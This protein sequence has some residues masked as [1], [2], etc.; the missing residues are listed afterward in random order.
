MEHDG[1]YRIHNSL[2]L[3]SVLT[4]FNPVYIIPCSPFNI[5]FNIILPSMPGYSKRSPAFYFPNQNSV[6]ISLL[7]LPY[8]IPRRSY[9]LWFNHPNVW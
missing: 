5:N 7:S 9:P 2:P 4:A 1:S 8:H 6:C 3:G